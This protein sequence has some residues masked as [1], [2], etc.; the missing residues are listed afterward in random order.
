MPSLSSTVASIGH[1]MVLLTAIVSGAIVS[2]WPVS[3]AAQ[4]T[5][6]ES[7]GFISINGGFQ[8]ANGFTGTVPVTLFV[9]EGSLTA[10]YDGVRAPISDLSAAGLV[11]RSLAVGVGVSTFSKEATAQ[12]SARLPHPFF[13][14]QHRNVSGT[15][16]G[17]TRSELAVHIQAMWVAPVHDSLSIAV[18][19]GPTFF[20][21]N[22]D[23]V[24]EVRANEVYPFD[25]TQFA[26]VSAVTA[27]ESSVGFNAGVDVG[28]FFS[29]HLGVGGLVRFSRAS[30]DFSVPNSRAVSANVGGL[31]TT[32]GL[33][34]RF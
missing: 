8:A 23:L 10:S 5:T 6:S 18:F 21:V 2:S 34:V 33:R 11:W 12:V 24:A 22:Q 30:V 31:L 27:S 17:L 9:E 20:R 19:G 13:F 3:V 15:G 1:G 4:Q 26:G 32:G 25:A 14:N 29:R 7:R 16:E 28:F